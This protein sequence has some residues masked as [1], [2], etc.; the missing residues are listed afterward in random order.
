MIKYRLR[1]HHVMCMHLYSGTG[2]SEAFCRQ[3][4]QLLQDCQDAPNNISIT[5]ISSC[6]DL[7]AVCPNRTGAIC[8]EEA[9]IRQRD[10]EVQAYFKLADGWKGTYADLIEQIRLP[11]SK[12]QRASDVCHRCQFYGLC[13]HVLPKKLPKINP[14]QR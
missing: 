13:D 14:I 2:Y 10:R 5:L 3:M 4:E 11:F 9:S 1:Y 8:K 6:D 12:I 7:C